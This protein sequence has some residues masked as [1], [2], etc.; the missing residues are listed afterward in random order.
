[1]KILIADDEEL[2]RQSILLFLMDLGIRPEDTFQVSD[3]LALLDVLKTTYFDLAL[4]DI[5]MPGMDGLEAIRRARKMAVETNFY[6]LSG[7]DDFKYAQAVIR[8]GVKDYILKPVK[9]KELQTILTGCVSLIKRRREKLS[10]SLNL[11]SLALINATGY[12]ANFPV[13]CHPLLIT[14][15]VPADP[16]PISRHAIEDR[17]EIIVVAHQVL[18]G[19]LL[20]IFAMPEYPGY[21]DAYVHELKERHGKRHTLFEGTPFQNSQNWD[22][23]FDRIKKLAALRPSFGSHVLYPHTCRVPQVPSELLNLCRL[24]QSCL[25]AYKKSDYA[26]FTISCEALIKSMEEIKRAYPKRVNHAIHFMERAFQLKALTME[27]FKKE[28]F[29]TATVLSSTLKDIP[30]EEIIDYITSH[31][32]ENISLSGLADMYQLSPNYFSTLFKK[33]TGCNFTRYLTSLRIGEGKRLLLETNLT[34]RE[35]A[36]R[37]GYYSTS[38]FIQSF[39]K[40]EQ[41]TPCQYRR[42]N[43]SPPA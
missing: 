12:E 27:L 5:R 40:A 29:L 8:L 33:K 23:D 24:C 7:F 35:I 22:A 6:V 11:N 42:Q 15:D 28:L 25:A 16:F 17:D 26:G 18:E 31:Y 9:K 32:M 37:V 14:D 13:L 21:C 41:V 39:K 38:F 34:I 1:M 3:G 43:Q 36:Q 4:V 10:E 20:F 19:T 30:Y 2:I